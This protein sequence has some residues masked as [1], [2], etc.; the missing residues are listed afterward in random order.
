MTSNVQVPVKD[1]DDIVCVE[2]DISIVD[3]AV[4][5]DEEAEDDGTT[6]ESL[7]KIKM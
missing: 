1:V 5:D 6:T 7:A 4:V 2:D 3:E